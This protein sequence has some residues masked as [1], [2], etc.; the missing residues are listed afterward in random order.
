M[1]EVVYTRICMHFHPV[2]R[3]A[4]CL[5]RTIFDILCRAKYIFIL[6]SIESV[7][8]E[9]FETG[10]AIPSRKTPSHCHL[11]VARRTSRVK[12]SASM[13]APSEMI[14]QYTTRTPING[15]GCACVMVNH[16]TSPHTCSMPVLASNV[17]RGKGSNKI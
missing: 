16:K 5:P 13:L 9:H 14:L 6:T 11:H 15:G 1:F 17:C 3:S 7:Y 12:G 10:R 4:F 8:A 2:L